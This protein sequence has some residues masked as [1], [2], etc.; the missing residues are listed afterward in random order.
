MRF[1]FQ[2]VVWWNIKES[3]LMKNLF[4]ATTAPKY[5][6][7]RKCWLLQCYVL[8]NFCFVRFVLA[9]SNSRIMAQ[10]PD[11]P[12]RQ[13]TIQLYFLFKSIRLLL[14][15]T[16]IN[17]SLHNIPVF[18]PLNSSVKGFKLKFQLKMHLTKCKKREIGNE[19]DTSHTTVRRKLHL[20]FSTVNW[21][22]RIYHF[23]FIAGLEETPRSVNS[24]ETGNKQQQF[25]S[26]CTI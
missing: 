10:P 11:G 17:S 21:E 13:K 25:E 19:K 6:N 22:V 18:F 12:H 24:R 16:F 7:W 26:K 8:M 2:K 4:T 5:I 3:I 23:Y 15:L 9:I 1:S 14:T 20:S